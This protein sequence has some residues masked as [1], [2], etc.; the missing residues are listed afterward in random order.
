MC[1]RHSEYLLQL[2]RHIRID[3]LG[4]CHRNR[5]EKEHPAL[6]AQV[7]AADPH[8]LSVASYLMSDLA[9]ISSLLRRCILQRDS[10]AIKHRTRT[11]SGGAAAAYRRSGG[12]RRCASGSSRGTTSSL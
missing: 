4:K 10:A 11:A 5:R 7:W 9:S 1:D 6:Q 2:M 12:S 3:S 8:P